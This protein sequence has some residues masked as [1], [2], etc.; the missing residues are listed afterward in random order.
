V[1]T[2]YWCFAPVADPRFLVLVVLRDPKRGR[3]AADNAAKVAGGIMGDLLHGFEV[4]PDHE[5]ELAPPPPGRSKRTGL[6]VISA[7]AGGEGQ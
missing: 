5:E 7:P 3:F 6:E 4:P 2:S 1:I